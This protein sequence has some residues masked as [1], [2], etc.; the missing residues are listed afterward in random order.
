MYTVLAELIVFPTNEYLYK[1]NYAL[2][3]LQAAKKSPAQS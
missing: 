2:K 1:T 3:R